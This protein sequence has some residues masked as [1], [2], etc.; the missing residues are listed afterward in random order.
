MVKIA[1]KLELNWRSQA[2]DNTSGDLVNGHIADWSDKGIAETSKRYDRF[3]ALNP[4]KAVSSDGV[5]QSNN[6]RILR[7]GKNY[8]YE[9]IDG[10]KDN[11]GRFGGIYAQSNRE[12][13]PHQAE[14]LLRFASEKRRQIEEARG[15]FYG[16][17]D[18][19]GFKDLYH[20]NLKQV[21]QRHLIRSI[22]KNIK[23]PLIVGGI[24][25]AG[26]LLATHKNKSD[27]TLERKEPNGNQ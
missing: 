26:Y 18:Y 5:G 1:A 25:G 21:N 24:V 9:F 15:S 6:L 8:S 19:S 4:L 3:S 13:K 23:A 7:D 22:K 10:A 27:Q 12:L 2:L 16:K 20:K 17:V 14:R 11:S